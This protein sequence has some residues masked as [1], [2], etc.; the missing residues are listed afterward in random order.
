M[1]NP[2]SFNARIRRIEFLIISII[3]FGY[4]AFYLSRIYNN[5]YSDSA[6]TP[7]NV[8]ETFLLLILM[9]ISSW[10]MIAATSR[11]LHDLGKSG[12]WQLLGYLFTFSFPFLLLYLLFWKGDDES[13]KY[14]EIPG[15][16]NNFINEQNLNTDKSEMNLKIILGKIIRIIGSIIF[17]VL[18]FGSALIATV[19]YFKKLHEWLG[20]WG[21]FLAIVT[22]LLGYF[23]FPFISWIVDGFSWEFFVLWGI[24]WIG[25]GIL[26]SR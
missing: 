13:N 21:I 16:K 2:F 9:I 20:G 14:G 19:I 12:W 24:V 8:T 22:N 18:F 4:F 26:G 11:R 15:I 10:I 25:S 3:Y 23:I 6:S 7:P 1:K 5:S 17:C